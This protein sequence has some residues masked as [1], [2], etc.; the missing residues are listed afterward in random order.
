M[1]NKWRALALFAVVAIISIFGTIFFYNNS[2]YHERLRAK[3]S[4]ENSGYSLSD[5]ELYIFEYT[6]EIN[7]KTYE[8]KDFSGKEVYYFD[9]Y[10]FKLFSDFIK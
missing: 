8:T 5:L 2:S 1:I 4:L 3:K 7:E 6:Y 9:G 10:K